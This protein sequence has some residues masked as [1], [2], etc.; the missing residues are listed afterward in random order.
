M[1]IYG[2]LHFIPFYFMSGTH[3]NGLIKRR[4]ALSPSAQ[5]WVA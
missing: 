4:N 1:Y 2:K 5:T 3:L